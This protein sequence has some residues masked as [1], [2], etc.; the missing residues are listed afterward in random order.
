MIHVNAKHILRVSG[1]FALAAGL[2]PLL[3]PATWLP[4]L[5]SRKPDALDDSAAGA[6]QATAV[7]RAFGLTSV[8]LGACTI[9]EADWPCKNFLVGKACHDAA[10][11]MVLW[12]L[13]KRRE[14]LGANK[15]GVKAAMLIAAVIAIAEGISA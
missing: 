8:A 9:A 4:T 11:A 1:V 2:H 13:L 12:G 5:F 3:L 15:K 6:A 7:T 10:L 14:E